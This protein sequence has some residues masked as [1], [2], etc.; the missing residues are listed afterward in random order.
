MKIRAISLH[1]PYAS[2]MALG[3]KLNETRHWPTKYRGPLA[4]HAAT[5]TKYVSG[6]ERRADCPMRRKL[7]PHFAAAGIILTEHF[8]LGC[9]VGVANLIECTPTEEMDLEL[10][11]VEAALGNYA[12]GRFAWRTADMFRLATPVPERG[13]QRWWS[14]EVPAGLD[15]GPHSVRL[16][17]CSPKLL[18]QQEEPAPCSK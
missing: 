12:D 17:G 13:R 9:I 18:K 3:L 1:Q 6:W 16:G 7:H 8:P 14:W 10:G 4:I 2:A 15:L 11:P 5:T